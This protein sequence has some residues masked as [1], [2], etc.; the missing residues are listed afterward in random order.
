MGGIAKLLIVLG[1]CLVA[2]GT[3]LG[4]VGKLPWLGRLPGDFTIERDGFRI[5][6]P[7]GTCV[8]LSLL[9]SALLWLFRR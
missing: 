6:L 1:L 8:L 2:L 7:L 9:L 3:L 4:L 5:Y